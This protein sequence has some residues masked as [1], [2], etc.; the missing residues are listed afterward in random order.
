MSKSNSKIDAFEMNLKQIQQTNDILHSIENRL[1]DVFLNQSPSYKKKIEFNEYNMESNRN[2]SP[3]NKEFLLNDPSFSNENNKNLFNSTTKILHPNENNSKK[4]NFAKKY[5]ENIDFPM[6]YNTNL[7]EKQVRDDNNYHSSIQLY[8]DYSPNKRSLYSVDLKTKDELDV[9]LKNLQKRLFLLEKENEIKSEELKTSRQRIFNLENNLSQY[10]S[11]KIQYTSEFNEL[12]EQK[13]D[14]NLA[15]IEMFEGRLREL[16][17]ENKALIREKNNYLTKIYELEEELKEK[18]RVMKNFENNKHEYEEKIA[19]LNKNHLENNKRII[20]EFKKEIINLNRQLNCLSKE[21]EDFSNNQRLLEKEKNKLNSSYSNLLNIHNQMLQIDIVKNEK[22]LQNSFSEANVNSESYRN[23]KKIIESLQSYKNEVEKLKTNSFVS[24][25][26][27]KELTNLKEE[28]EKQKKDNFVLIREMDQMKNQKKIEKLSEKAENEC[29][30]TEKETEKIKKAKKTEA[31]EQTEN[32]EE[33]VKKLEFAYKNVENKYNEQIIINKEM[34]ENWKEIEFK[35]KDSYEKIQK[36]YKKFCEDEN[37]Q[38]ITLPSNENIFKSC[39][40]SMKN[41]VPTP[42][43]KNNSVMGLMKPKKP[44]FN[45][46]K[47]ASNANI[48]SLKF[49]SKQKRS[50]SNNNLKKK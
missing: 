50:T 42:E 45:V 25:N 9:D 3:P 24:E 31:S 23:S 4:K 49:I 12:N 33:Y 2:M 35:N 22:N 26:Y 48:H 36:I 20:E 39:P 46:N 13:K 8:E 30:K 37:L 47:T 41:I 7:R 15:K 10:K 14:Y 44:I 34:K 43:N 38:K 6:E 1:N 32:M 16:N 29:E 5:D 21:K 19:I 17:D 18:H 27:L 28:I 11:Q 40:M